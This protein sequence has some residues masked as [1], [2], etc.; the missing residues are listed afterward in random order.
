MIEIFFRFKIANIHPVLPV[1]KNDKKN[2][3]Q[4]C[5]KAVIL[6]YVKH[7][8]TP[9]IIKD[10]FKTASVQFILEKAILVPTEVTLLE[11][12]KEELFTSCLQTVEK[13]N[14]TYITE[15][16]VFISYLLITEQHTR[17]LFSKKLKPEDMY[18]IL[19]WARTY[20]SQAEY[21]KPFR[22]S[23]TE[24][25]IG[26]ALTTGWTLETRKYTQD[27]T[28]KALQKGALIT[29]REKEFER[30]VE[31]LTKREK[32]NVLLIGETGVGKETLVNALSY[33]SFTGEITG[34]L[35]Y[36]RVYML[37]V[38]A[39]LAGTEN[40]GELETRLQAIIEEVTHAGNIILYIPEFQDILGGSSF[41]LDISGAL[42]P[43]LQNGNLPVIASITA[44]AYKNYV[45]KS[46]LFDVLTPIQVP[47]PDRPLAIRM[48][49]DKATQIE[50]NNNVVL[51]YRSIV[52]SVDL[53]N[54]YMVDRVLPGSAVTLLEDTAQK[55]LLSKTAV[56]SQRKKRIV[57]EEDVIS[58]IEEKTKV[59]VGTPSAEEKNTLL[60]LEEKLHSRVIGQDQAVNAVSEAIR[61]VRTGVTTAAKPISFLFLGP[62][63]VGKTETA[64]ALAQYYFHGEQN[65]IRLD[66]SEYSTE[67]GVKRLLGAMP[68]EGEE[69]GELT[70]KIHDH[71]F[72]VVL[73]DEFEK[74]NPVILNLFLQVLEDGRLTDNKGRTVLF[75]DTIII[76]TSN[77]GSEFIREEVQEGQASDTSFHARLL[78]YLQVNN[79]FKPELLN[80]FDG[81]IT[82]M[83][84]EEKQIENVAR[85]LLEKLKSTMAAQDVTL[86]YTDSLLQK[87]AKDAYSDQF[88]ARPVKRYI[89]DEIESV[90]SQKILSEEIARGK[91]I[92]VGTDEQ[93]N[94]SFTVA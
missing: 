34:Y 7:N 4:S 50:R 2:I 80:R 14:G 71:P 3:F 75:I 58:E 59:T 48:L 67:N 38:G 21:N 55:V 52:T 70:E 24:E 66:M 30:M 8:K 40:R 86:T 61:R 16:D 72:S 22:I 62:T 81:V 18:Q 20:Y 42:L 77:A 83:P 47:E 26:D 35:Q 76:A 45:E 9:A 25:G 65:M 84:L 56:L 73:L 90:L 5:T 53:A 88:G 63:G 23:F 46:S 49:F 89:Q 74:A 1:S 17:L 44:G 10:M 37:L 82:F 78:E 54:K 51:S 29:G 43:Y 6:S 28:K 31:S 60:N 68:G 92:Q 19:F 15:M 69:R 91:T 79:I 64:K 33:K 87:I 27:M 94:L 36:K 93:N 13:V 11:I 32:N 39:F 85:L 57:R 12:S 41:G